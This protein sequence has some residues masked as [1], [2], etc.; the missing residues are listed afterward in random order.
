VKDAN[1]KIDY[2]FTKDVILSKAP[3]PTINREQD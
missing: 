3:E 1:T 2:N